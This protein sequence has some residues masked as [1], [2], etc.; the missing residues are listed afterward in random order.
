MGNK[1]LREKESPGVS[2]RSWEES[3]TRD[4]VLKK[5]RDHAMD[6]KMRPSGWSRQGGKDN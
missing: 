3:L 6:R 2:K 4:Q 1:W 5:F